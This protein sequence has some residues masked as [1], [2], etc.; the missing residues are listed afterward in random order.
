MAAVLKSALRALAGLA[1]LAGI[2]ACRPSAVAGPVL[3]TVSI[4]GPLTLEQGSVVDFVVTVTKGAGRA[5][6]QTFLLVLPGNVRRVLGRD[7]DTGAPILSDERTVTVDDL[8]PNDGPATIQYHLDLC[9]VDRSA[10]FISAGL[11]P[12]SGTPERTR[13]FTTAVLTVR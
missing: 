11:Y 7:P 6:R 12:S 1:S 2:A 5:S 10:A 3:F 13:S 9:G 8:D 4:D